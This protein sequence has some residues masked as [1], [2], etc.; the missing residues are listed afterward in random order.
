MKNPKEA[1]EAYKDE[2]FLDYSNDKKEDAKRFEIYKKNYQ[3]A[4]KY[5]EKFLAGETYHHVFSDFWFHQTPK[6]R[7]FG[8]K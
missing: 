3:I 4:I 1:W 8:K 5:N 2:N 7:N 6:E